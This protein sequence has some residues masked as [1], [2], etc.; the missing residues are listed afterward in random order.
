[1]WIELLKKEV[2]AKGAKQ[3]AHE[4]GMSRTTVDLVCHGKYPGRTRKVE[5]RIKS[6][7]GTGGCVLCPVLDE[8]TPLRCADT[9]SRAKIIGMKAGNPETL[10]LYKACSKCTVRGI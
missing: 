6:I 9:W 1:M 5:E 10:K 7:Y 3:V 8:I 4:L 2:T